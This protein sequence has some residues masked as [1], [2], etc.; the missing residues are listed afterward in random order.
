MTVGPFYY[1]P[2]VPPLVLLGVEGLARLPRRAVIVGVAVVLLVQ[3]AFL[4]NHLRDQWGYG[5]GG[6]PPAAAAPPAPR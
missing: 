6:N 1:L 4:T 2:C 5:R 3:A